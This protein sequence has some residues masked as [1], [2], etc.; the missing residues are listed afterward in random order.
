ME[1]RERLLE[2]TTAYYTGSRVITF[3]PIATCTYLA[4]RG[5]NEG[6]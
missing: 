5:D 3:D 1:I 2:I 6:R 4:M